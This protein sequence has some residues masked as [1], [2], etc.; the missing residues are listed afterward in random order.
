MTTE[1]AIKYLKSADT[2]VGKKIKTRT[3]EALEMA[4]KALEQTYGDLI[5]R[6]ELLNKIWQKEYG[7]DYDGVNLLK[8]PHIDIIEQ[9]PS[10]EKTESEKLD[11]IIVRVEVQNIYDLLT[12]HTALLNDIKMMMPSEKTAEWIS[13]RKQKPE[14][15]EEVIATVRYDY[16]NKQEYEVV[17]GVRYSKEDG[18]ECA[19][20][21]GADYW[22]SINGV[23]VAWQPLPKPY[24]VKR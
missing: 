10:A 2:T 24:E 6:S 8:I 7:K 20:E 15:Y 3:A 11:D 19:Y 23:V 17:T 12:R 13:V 22:E 4:I 9:M 16:G 18:W 5:S 14:D 1:E 21:A